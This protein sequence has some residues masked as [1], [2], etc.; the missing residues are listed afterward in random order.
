MSPYVVTA[1]EVVTTLGSSDDR[2]SILRGW[3]RHREALRGIGFNRGF[4]WLDGSFVE[5]KIPH[6]RDEPNAK[7]R[8]ARLDWITSV[9]PA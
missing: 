7:V 2:K 8:T 9:R 5:N 3:L 4:Q 6:K 1:F